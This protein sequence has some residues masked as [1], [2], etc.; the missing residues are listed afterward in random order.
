MSVNKAILI[1]NL[2]KDPEQRFTA[3]GT[4]VCNFTVAT[5]EK[6][7]DKSG[8]WQER[9]EFHNIVAWAKL[10]EICAKYLQ[11][12]KQVYIEGRIQTRSY[13]DKNG[14]K[15]Y[16]TEIVADQ[17]KMLGSSVSVSRENADIPGTGRQSEEPCRTDEELGI[18]F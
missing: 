1:G 17:M 4:A 18:P 13:D 15:K 10:A 8:E 14:V 9:A 16:T 3:S 5:N 7:K 12:G 6:Y 2:T 11:K